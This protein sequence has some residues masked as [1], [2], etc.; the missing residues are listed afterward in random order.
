LWQCKNGLA[1]W[2]ANV[3]I[4]DIAGAQHHCHAKR[5]GGVNIF[6]GGFG[7]HDQDIVMRLYL[8]GDAPRPALNRNR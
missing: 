2:V 5:P 1:L 6:G 8:R 4:D 7:N 3:I